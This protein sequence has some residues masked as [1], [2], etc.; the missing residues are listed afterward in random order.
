[1]LFALQ[2]QGFLCFLCFFILPFLIFEARGFE[3]DFSLFF[4]HSLST[5]PWLTP[6]R[7]ECARY[8]TQWICATPR[9]PSGVQE[10][11][12]RQPIFMPCANR[13]TRANPQFLTSSISAQRFIDYTPYVALLDLL[14]NIHLSTGAGRDDFYRLRIPHNDMGY[15]RRD[16]KNPSSRICRKAISDIQI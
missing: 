13:S 8:N 12:C 4:F 16:N 14:V 10:E 11:F 3:Y 9:S 15:W 6:C 7:S 2:S 5:S 1:V